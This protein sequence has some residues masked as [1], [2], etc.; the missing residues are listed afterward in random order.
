MEHKRALLRELPK[1]YD[2]TVELI[3]S[4]KHTYSKAVSRLIVFE[5][6]LRSIDCASTLE[7]VT[8]T[9]P[10]KPSRKCFYCGK[11]RKIARDCRKK[12]AA[13]DIQDYNN[14]RRCF[15][16]GEV[17]NIEK[18]CFRKNDRAGSTGSKVDVAMVTVTLVALL[19]ATDSQKSTKGMLDSCC[20]KHM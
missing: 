20:S 10:T 2:A 1:D 5:T 12:K 19:M 7:L 9:V 14:G 8:T 16:C 11:P 13:E 3:I 4:L 6:R 17:G 18:N 15:K